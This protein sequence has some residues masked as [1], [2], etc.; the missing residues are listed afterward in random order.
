MK[1]LLVPIGISKH[2]EATFQYAMDV[3]THFESTLYVVDAYPVVLNPTSLVNVKARLEDENHQRIKDMT[4]LLGQDAKNIKIVR[5]ERDLVGTVKKL[6]KTIGLDLIVTAPLSN[7]IDEKVFLDRIAGSMIKRTNIPVLVA[8]IN[9]T[10]KAPKNIL[11][12]FKDGEIRSETTLIPLHQFQDAFESLVNL[13]LVKVP[14]YGNPNHTLSDTIL[15]RSE[16][17][18]FSENATVYQGVLEH[19]QNGKPDMLAVFKRER[20]FFVKLWESDIIYRKDFYCTI[21]L[22]ILKNREERV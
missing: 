21:P 8:P 12:A 15:S 18:R 3:A 2:A 17:L 9:E 10:F 7:N 11:L 20:G 19:F 22:I 4:S 13:L 5:S 6:N 16:E 1:N 14:G